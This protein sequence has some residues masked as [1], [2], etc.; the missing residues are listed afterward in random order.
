VAAHRDGI[1]AFGATPHHRMMFG[2]VLRSL[3][4]VQAV[5]LEEQ[6]TILV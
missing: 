1:R 4:A 5:Q 2:E 6:Q 3:R